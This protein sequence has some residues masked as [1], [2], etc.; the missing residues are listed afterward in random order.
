MK[1]RNRLG[2]I[3]L[4]FFG[5][6][7]CE[8]HKNHVPKP[9]THLELKFPNRN[10]DIYIDPCGYT[11]NK[12]S[13]FDIGDVQGSKCNRDISF[14]TL[15]GVMHL[16]RIDMDTTLAAYINY[17]INKVDEHKVKA[18][19]ILDTSII[20]ND[21]RVFGTLFE[22]QGNVASP[23]QFYLTDS[24]SRFINGVVYF[25]S[26]PNYDSIKPVLEFVKTDILE[27]MTTLQWED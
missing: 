19:A 20:R 26:E 1:I 24:T 15:N 3:L 25:D 4:L 23:F 14:S 13:Y 10:Y 12:P 5:L 17:S 7:S 21:A 2:W 6:V 8:G 22:L 11:F 18:T 9:S 27:L 16:S